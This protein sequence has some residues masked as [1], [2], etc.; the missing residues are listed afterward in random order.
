[1]TFSGCLV[2]VLAAIVAVVAGEVDKQYGFI[3]TLPGESCRDIYQKNPYC[4]GKS[5][6]YVIVIG[7]TPNFVYCDM[8]LECGGEKGWMRVTDIDSAK[9]SCP[10]GW[11]KI[12]SPVAACRAPSDNAGC[13][14]AQFSTHQVP[15]SRVCGMVI[16]Y[17]KGT[18]DGFRAIYY[19]TRSI[20]GPYVD[21]VS[22]T[23][24][25]PRKHIWSYG[26]GFNEYGHSSSCPC[27][28]HGGTLPTSFV[29]ENYYC[30]SGSYGNPPSGTYFTRDPLWDGKDCPSENSCCSEPNL[31][32]F[33]RQIPL[34]SDNNIEARI[35]YDQSFRDEGVLVKETKLYIQ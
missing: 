33:Y 2:A 27:A 5:G 13:Y 3:P 4:H 10:H 15:Y 11:K 24:G 12:T 17:Q 23:Y 18:P 34:T 1:M 8:E 7:T 20:D 21:G 35:C 32:W 19:G 22:I 30:E 16:G 28:R 29:H 14:S 26:V 31:P 6:Y 25:T 9:D